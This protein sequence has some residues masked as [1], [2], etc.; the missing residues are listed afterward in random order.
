MQRRRLSPPLTPTLSPLC[1]T[2][3][4]GRR[5]DDGDTGAMTAWER[6][7]ETFFKPAMIAQYWPDILK[8]VLVT[9]EIAATVVVTG[10]ALG[11]ALATLRAY[12]LSFANALIVVFVD[13]FR[14]L[15]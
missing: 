7:V 4:R 6:F 8:G 14:A 2:M 10:L 12:R 9:V 3:G 11:L 1:R 13:V 5:T 15:P